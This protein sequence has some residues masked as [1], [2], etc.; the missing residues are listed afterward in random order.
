MRLIVA[1]KRLIRYER[2]Y[3]DP[4]SAHHLPH[5][6]AIWFIAGVER[7]LSGDAK[8]LESA[9]GL[10]RPGRPVN[11]YKPENL[12]RAEQ[13]ICLR[14]Q[15]M[16]LEEVTQ[17]LYE[18]RK[19]PPSARYVQ[20][21]IKRFTSVIIDKQCQKIA[22]G[23]H[24]RWLARRQTPPRLVRRLG[25]NQ[26][27]AIWVDANKPLTPEDLMR[28]FRRQVDTPRSGKRCDQDQ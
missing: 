3:P 15:G 23:L 26:I 14:E 5:R 4:P 25:E 27:Q 1:T 7:F 9:L 12:A 10:K 20:T 6:D 16:T 24:Q 17:T 2:R 11:L 8:S 22:D 28:V 13:A 21:L 18:H 19:D